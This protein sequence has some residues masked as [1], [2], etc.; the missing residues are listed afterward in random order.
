MKFR[1]NEN[2]FPGRRHTKKNIGTE[3]SFSRFFLSLSLP[4]CSRINLYLAFLWSGKIGKTSWIRPIRRGT[5]GVAKYH[6]TVRKI[7]W[8][9]PKY[10]VENGRKTD[11]ASMIGHAYL[12]LYPSCM[13]FYVK[14]A[15]PEPQPSQ[16]KTGVRKR[17]IYRY[18]VRKARILDVL[19]I[20]S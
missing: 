10:R 15:A 5:L 20:S 17:E 12:M 19:P 7:A 11:T 4:C 3:T 16:L 1:F 6:N 18:N 8:Q 14:H 2:G 9:I 13:F